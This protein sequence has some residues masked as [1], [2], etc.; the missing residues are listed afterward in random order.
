LLNHPQQ[1]AHITGQSV[2]AVDV[3]SIPLTEMVQTLSQSWLFLS[4]PL[5]LSVKR[6]IEV[7]SIKLAVCLLVNATHS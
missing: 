5:A 6:L 1:V 2:H 7:H 3:Q 4:L